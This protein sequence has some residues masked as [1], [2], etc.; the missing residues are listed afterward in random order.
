MREGEVNLLGGLIQQQ[1]NK[2]VT[3]IP[4]LSSIP[5]IRRLFSGESVDRSKSELMIALIPH[6]IRRP[7]ITPDNLRA[8]GVGNATSIKLSYAPESP[9]AAPAPRPAPPAGAPVPPPAAS[10]IPPA[11][12]R[13]T[14]PPVTPATPPTTSPIGPPATAPPTAAPPQP[15]IPVPGVPGLAAPAPANRQG[16]APGAASVRFLP[17]RVDTNVQNTFMVAVAVNNAADLASAPIQ[18]QFDPKVLR[19]NDIVTGDFLAQG[20]TRV[21]FTKN[22]QNDSGT[23]TV[24]LNRPSGAPGVSGSGVL[25]TLSFQAVGKG[26]T[27][28][29][30][31]NVNL[32]NTQ[33]QSLGDGNPGLPVR[34]Q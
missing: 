20:G 16:A 12:A 30:L 21:N 29:T 1:E 27:T 5:L 34:I 24:T 11:A 15:G 26:N 3:G 9:T 8:I 4:G 18:I 10:P 19:L 2:T 14:T 32:Q 25:M 31:S 6:I 13:Q 23:A 28:V 33:N 22:I 7:D 17:D